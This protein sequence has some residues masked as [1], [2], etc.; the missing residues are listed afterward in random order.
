MQRKKWEKIERVQRNASTVTL[1]NLV[2]WLKKKT[3]W[4]LRS[5]MWRG[6]LLS[7]FC[8]KWQ[9]VSWWIHSLNVGVGM[10]IIGYEISSCRDLWKYLKNKIEWD[11]PGGTVN[12]N[13]PANAGNTHLI[14]GLG[15]T[16]MPKSNKGLCAT[17]TEPEL[18]SLRAATTGPEC[19]NYWSLCA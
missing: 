18:Y 5:V 11:F 9:K 2:I 13:P 19:Q 16:H 12:R 3:I 1:K 14:P 7:D 4:K 6:P 15:R 17:A 10:Y 8:Q